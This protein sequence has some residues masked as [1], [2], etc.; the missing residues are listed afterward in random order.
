M[1]CEEGIVSVRRLL[2]IDDAVVNPRQLVLCASVARRRY[3]NRPDRG[4][5]FPLSH[6][7]HVSVVDRGHVASCAVKAAPGN[8]SR[9][10]DSK[11]LF[12]F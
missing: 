3:D 5:V 11:S 8:V 12:D 2:Y 7:I 4:P 6:L 10:T 1:K 9:A